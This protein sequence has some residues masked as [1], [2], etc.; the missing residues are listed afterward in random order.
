[1]IPL[2][3]TGMGAIAASGS[4]AEALWQSALAGVSPAQFWAPASKTAEPRVP[5]CAV[6][7][8]ELTAVRVRWARKLDRCVHLATQAAT[9]AW[10][11]AQLASCARDRIGVVVGSA[12]GP[13]GKIIEADR[14]V[15]RGRV[16]PSLSASTTMASLSGAL[17]L[18]FQVR[19]PCFSVSASCAS[20]GHAIAL[21]ADMVAGGLVD[22]MVAGGAEA[23]LLGA[24][25]DP[26]R[27]SGIMAQHADPRLACRPFD[28]QRTGLMLGEGAA[29]LVIESIAHA[30]Q[31]GMIP[32]GFLQGW[33]M[34]AE[35]WNRTAAR[36]DGEGLFRV[37]TQALHRA[38]IPAERV[39][40]FNAH[41]TGTRLNDRTEA[42]AM[43]RLLG[44][45][46]DRIPCSSTKPITGHCLGAS[47]ALEA[48]LSLM[49]LRDQRVPPTANCVE[50]DPDC[51]LDVVPGESRAQPLQVVVSQSQGFWGNNAALVFVRDYPS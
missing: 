13:A 9:Q 22:V 7:D 37:L 1:M 29:F 15:S 33:A 11:Q 50:L 20:S 5:V 39:D 42:V 16:A 21:A 40:Y 30:S 26:F 45:R 3:V 24:V 28:R 25:I 19:G 10:N 23:P 8:A 46:R 2:A 38:E 17:S 34:G 35:A 14:Q 36:E 44:N 12:R 47:P 49:A 4:N 27:V 32:L 48:V 6:S 41:G 51:A 18:G 31:R 43:G